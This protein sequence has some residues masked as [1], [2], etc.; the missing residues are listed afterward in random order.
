LQNDER[1]SLTRRQTEVRST[2]MKSGLTASEPL[3]PRC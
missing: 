1:V 3:S 2:P